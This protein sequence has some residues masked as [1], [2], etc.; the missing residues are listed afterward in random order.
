MTSCKHSSK[1]SEARLPWPAVVV[2]VGAQC[3]D[4]AVMAPRREQVFVEAFLAHPSFK[5]LDQAVMH[6][7]T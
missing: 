3:R 2:V 4:R 1:A 7:F 6:G 5:A